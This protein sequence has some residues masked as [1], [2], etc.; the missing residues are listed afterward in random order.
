M[1][2]AYKKLKGFSTF[3]YQKLYLGKDHLLVSD[4]YMVEQYRRLYFADIQMI[5]LS[6]TPVFV[7]VNAIFGVVLLIGMI[8]VAGFWS[9]PG[10]AWT[11]GVFFVG[12]P[13]I[14]LLVNLVKGPSCLLEIRT[15][16]Q[17]LKLRCV[18]RERKARSILRR[19]TPLIAQAQ[20][21]QS[22]LS[23][24]ELEAGGEVQEAVS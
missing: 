13:A 8:L 5:S 12:F 15:G 17:H 21:R 10:A 9:N 22:P 24:E 20:G 14:V 3:A 11:L 19:T 23:T 16:V 7:T 4:G 1:K 6:R 2:K 18:S